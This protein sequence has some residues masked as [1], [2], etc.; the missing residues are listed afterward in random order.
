MGMGSYAG[1]LLVEKL[2][3]DNHAI[4]IAVDMKRVPPMPLFLLVLTSVELK[5]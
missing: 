2:L 5:F 1:V 3:Q 4:V